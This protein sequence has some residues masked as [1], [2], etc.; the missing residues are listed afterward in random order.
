M[1]SRDDDDKVSYRIDKL[2]GSDD[3]ATWRGDVRMLIRA[4]DPELLG[5]GT[6]TAKQLCGC[7]RGLEEG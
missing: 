5:S 2:Q 7:S 1:S 4:G 6:R 3:Y